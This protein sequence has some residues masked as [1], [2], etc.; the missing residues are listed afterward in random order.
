M[1]FLNPKVMLVKNKQ[2]NDKFY[3]YHEILAA[4]EEDREK[5]KQLPVI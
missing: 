2:L 1:A 3:Q 5:K 4:K